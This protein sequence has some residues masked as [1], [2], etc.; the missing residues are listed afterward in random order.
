MRKISCAIVA[1]SVIGL[2]GQAEAANLRFSHFL[3]PGHYFDNDVHAWADAL[4]AASNGDITVQ[5]FPA[6]QLGAPA[7]QYDMARDGI[8]DV[9]WV[10]FGYQPGAFPIAD[11]I[12]IPFSIGADRAVASRAV[13]DW[14]SEYAPTEMEDVHFCLAHVGPPGTLH[15]AEE[16]ILPA[17]VDGMK[18]RPASAALSQFIADLGGSAVQ[19]PATEARQAIERGVANAITFP[20]GSLE[21]FGIA[22][23][24]PYHIGT[25]FYYVGAGLVMNKASYERLSDED[26]AAVDSVCSSEWAEKLG[27]SWVEFENSGRAAL[28]ATGGHTVH[29]PTETELKAWQDA[30]EPSFQ[31][32][33]DRV[34]EAGYDADEVRAKLQAALT[35]EASK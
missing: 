14:Y 9:A 31:R 26:K 27:A 15:S 23:A 12:D 33:A 22:D 13:N 21:F 32:W 4:N 8:V 3:P 28:E 24:V 18:V 10:N 30:A 19:V 17:D 7:D 5:V 35:S 25:N 6:G 11:L 16:V 1:A 29:D 2:V 20:W 34:N